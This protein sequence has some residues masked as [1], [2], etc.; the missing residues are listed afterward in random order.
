MDV[1]TPVALKL[2]AFGLERLQDPNWTGMEL[3]DYLK[4]PVRRDAFLKTFK[5]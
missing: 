3:F 4:R 1:Y 5:K 2:H